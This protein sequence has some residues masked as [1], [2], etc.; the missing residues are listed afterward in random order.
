MCLVLEAGVPALEF[1][2]HEPWAVAVA[3]VTLLWIAM[4][5]PP[6]RGRPRADARRSEAPASARAQPAHP[7]RTRARH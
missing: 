5:V 1:R 3:A 6:A 7:H 4:S 2:S